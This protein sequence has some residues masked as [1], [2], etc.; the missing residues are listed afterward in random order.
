MALTAP[1]S[2][3]T[4]NWWFMMI[5]AAVG[6][7]LWLIYDGSFN[8]TFIQAHTHVDKTTGAQTPDTTLMFNQKSPP[9]FFGAA[10]LMAFWL[11]FIWRK[12]VIADETEL[13]IDGKLHIPYE[14]IDQIDKTDFTRKG[15]FVITYRNAHGKVTHRTLKDT[16]YDRLAPILEHLVKQLVPEDE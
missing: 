1:L 9:F 13:I 10:V 7:G 6:I 2:R 8:Q 11:A 12:Q 4:R 3:Q 14:R 16:D 5:V 15:R